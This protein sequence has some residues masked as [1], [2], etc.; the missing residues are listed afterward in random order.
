MPTI[1]I[2]ATYIW[3]CSHANYFS[4]KTVLMGTWEVQGKKL[5]AYVYTVYSAYSTRQILQFLI[6][7]YFICLAMV[8]G[9]YMCF[10][11][12]AEVV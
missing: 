8:Y 9:V 10:H 5:V 1:S 7:M 2:C 11:F 12:F 4:F 3:W 6:Y